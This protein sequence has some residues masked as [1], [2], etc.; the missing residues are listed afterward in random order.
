MSMKDELEVA[1]YV[2]VVSIGCRGREKISLDELVTRP[3]LQEEPV[4]VDREWPWRDARHRKGGTRIFA[5]RR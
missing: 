4:V 5:N 2:L 1:G 3:R